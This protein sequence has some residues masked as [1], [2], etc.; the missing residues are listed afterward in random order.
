MWVSH[1]R[2]RGWE[3]IETL[4]DAAINALLVDYVG[5]TI[6]L[7]VLA[8]DE[9]RIS[10]DAGTTWAGLPLAGAEPTCL[11]APSGLAPGA[12]LLAGCADGLVEQL[13]A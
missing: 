9:I 4:G 3:R 12:H 7:A 1:D 11:A 6:A 5:E 2:G 13:S 10:R 8:D